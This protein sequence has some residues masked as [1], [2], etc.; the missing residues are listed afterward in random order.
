MRRLLVL[1]LVVLGSAGAAQAGDLPL[2]AEDALQDRALR[3]EE[4][5]LVAVPMKLTRI[6][7]GG[8]SSPAMNILGPVT[9]VTPAP[10]SY[11]VAPCWLFVVESA[12]PPGG[13]G[14]CKAQVGPALGVG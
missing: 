11:S 14:M 4:H 9:P 6:A 12:S 7:P 1:A 13:D 10:G 2:T 5:L 8:V 3:P